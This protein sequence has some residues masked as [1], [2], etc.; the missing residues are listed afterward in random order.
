MIVFRERV[1]PSVPNLGLPLLLF[2]SVFAV[3]LPIDAPLALPVALL[4]TL[5]FVAVIFSSAPSIQV[6]EATLTAK[7]ATIE[8]KNLGAA[9]VIPK[10]EVFRALGP[11]LHA[12]AWLAIQ[13]SV[14]GLVRVEVIDP[15]DPTPYW[16]ISTRHPEKLAELLNN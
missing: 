5:S 9:K 3:M 8:L 7:G 16:L 1:L 13:A 2:P 11:E 14:K 15:Q 10:T 12:K 6:T 4:C